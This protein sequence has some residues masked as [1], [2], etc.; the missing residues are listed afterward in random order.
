MA[1]DMHIGIDYSGAATADR[2]L[3]GLRVFAAA[4]GRMPALA[5]P[6][7]RVGANWTRREVYRYCLSAIAGERRVIIGIDHAFGFP[8][9]YLERN[10]HGTWDEFLEDFARRWP[11][12]EPDATVESLRGANGHEGGRTELRLCERWTAGA[13][14]VFWFD[15]Q[16]SVAKSTRAGIPWLRCLRRDS[17]VRGR[18]HFWPFDGFRIPEGK[19]V[20]AEA[21]PS[22]WRKRYDVEARTADEQDAYATSR[23]LAEMDR[24]GELGRYLRPPL[25]DDESRTA[26]LE[27]WILGIA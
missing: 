5:D 9:R 20:I 13:K 6:G 7:A 25:T 26:L 15:V 23:W 10:G 12:T 1:F 22:L 14:S 24:R 11:T 2:R 18:V 16:G 8:L 21:Y 19:S 4:G 27:G 17:A 3:R